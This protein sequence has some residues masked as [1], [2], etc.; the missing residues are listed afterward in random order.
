MTVHADRMRDEPRGHPRRALLAAR[1]A[2]AGRGGALARR[3][4]PDRPGGRPARLGRGHRS[5]ATCSREAAPELD[6]DAVFDPAAFV[7][8]ARTIV[9]APRP[10]RLARPDL[11]G[12]MSGDPRRLRS[13]TRRGPMRP[14][15]PGRRGRRAPQ[16]AQ[17]RRKTKPALRASA[18]QAPASAPALDVSAS[19]GTAA[20]R[21]LRWRPRRSRASDAARST[22]RTPSTAR[23][24]AASGG[25]GVHAQAQAQAQAGQPGRCR[26]PRSR[27]RPLRRHRSGLR[28]S[29]PIAVYSGPFG[30]RQAERL[31]WRA[32]F[33][34]SPGHAEAL[35]AAGPAPRGGR[36][37]PAGG[38]AHLHGRAARLQAYELDADPVIPI[39][40][41]D[42]YGPRPPLVPR[43]H[44]PH[45]PAAGR[46]HD[47]GLAR[48]VRHLQRRRRPAR[49]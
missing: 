42:R 41:I 48:L 38:A 9:A 1:A 7:R 26:R 49:A 31:L 32:G 35:A 20:A 22:R 18:P 34:P 28:L 40:P 45:R 8:H 16:Q 15:G 43:P 4:L 47:A 17:A 10:H 12:Q 29:S 27:R 24:S 11:A 25:S 6:L 44:G 37:H 2:R 5:S 23:A 13:E 3:G 30:V 14:R 19:G 36:P 21:R 33:G 46:A 39:K